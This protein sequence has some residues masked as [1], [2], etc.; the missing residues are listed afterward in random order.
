VGREKCASK[1]DALHRIKSVTIYA[2]S[3]VIA[4]PSRAAALRI[5]RSATIIVV[6]RIGLGVP[7]AMSVVRQENIVSLL[8][9]LTENTAVVTNA[10]ARWVGIVKFLKGKLHLNVSNHDNKMVIRRCP[11][12]KWRL[13]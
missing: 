3:Q 5:K 6:I 4:A 8:P 11:R 2:V 12:S 10:V 7:Y 13:G 1:T 9:A